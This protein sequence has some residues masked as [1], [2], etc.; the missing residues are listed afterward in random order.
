MKSVAVIPLIESR[1]AEALR[2]LAA[3]NNGNLP[4]SLVPTSSVAY[5]S[6]LDDVPNASDLKD[7][8]APRVT[9]AEEEQVKVMT[10]V[11]QDGFEHS[12]DESEPDT[13]ASSPAESLTSTPSSEFSVMTGNIAKT[14][15]DRLSFWNKMSKKP[16]VASTTSIDQVIAGEA[17]RRLPSRQ[18]ST[19]ERTS[20]DALLKEGD[21]KPEEILDAIVEAHSPAPM[22]VDQKN[23]ELEEKIIREVMHQFSRGMYFAYRFG[24]CINQRTFAQRSRNPLDIT[25][26]L[27]QK[28]EI[29]SKAKKRSSLLADLNALDEQHKLSPDDGKVHVLAEPSATLPLWRRVDRQYWWNEWL[30]KPLLDAGVRRLIFKYSASIDSSLVAPHICSAYHAGIFPDRQLR[31]TPRTR[32]FRRG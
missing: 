5:P 13:G 32:S 12:E 18:G 6:S 3:R 31:H 2:A 9:F 26:S 11:A 8:S 20:I 24:Q 1:A 23:S 27:Q 16:T 17:Q 25:R 22:T 15:A 21:K 29:I 7:P 10:P 28:Q 30:S 4:V 14:L 19:D